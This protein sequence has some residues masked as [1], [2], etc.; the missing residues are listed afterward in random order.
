MTNLIVRMNS[1]MNSDVLPT[2]FNSKFGFVYAAVLAVLVTIIYYTTLVIYNVYFHPLSKF[3]GTRARAATEW[4]YFLSMINGTGP[5]DMLEM[6]EK[7]GPIVRVS[8]GELAFCS[9]AAFKDIYGRRKD[10]P[11]ELAK[12]KK[13]YSGMGEPTLLNSD[14][15]A[16]HSYLRK[17]LSPSFS[18]FSLRKQEAVIQDYLKILMRKLEK[19]SQDYDGGAD[20]LQWFNFFV[21]DV[22]GYLTY[23]ET[24]DCLNSN[25]L[26][27]W[28]KLIPPLGKFY[29]FYQAVARLPIWL[30]Y[31]TLLL[32]MPRGLLSDVKTLGQISETKVKQRLSIT[33]TIPDLMGK[34]IEEYN[35]GK[36]TMNQLKS[37]A[38]FLIGAGSETLVT[39]F[40]HCVYYLLMNPHT[41]SKLTSE[42]RG[43]FSTAD[44]ITMVN[45]NQCKY[46]QAVIDE[47]LRIVAPSPATH[48]RYTPPGGIDI[49]GVFVPG[50]MAV[51]VPILAACRSSLNFHNPTKFVPERWTGEDP[52]YVNDA[53]DAA[54]VFSYGPRDCLGR[55]LAYVEMR[56]VMAS[57]VWH[58]DLERR[59]PEDWVDQKVYMVW[60]KSP[61]MV[62]L[63]PVR[64]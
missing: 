12:D 40:T 22:I 56:L 39:M 15:M 24:F 36:M 33:A 54:Q 45:V 3:P 31:P 59:F 64:C 4:P 37:N 5:Q 6:H 27:T 62:K 53:R 28:I 46:L 43:S 25:E 20:L 17:L 60:V 58:F 63:K 42:I 48:P 49:D 50:G 9:P 44:E 30:K 41:L 51:G 21:F 55:N 7:Y 32:G 11:P 26:H 35:V 18:D 47:T 38:S 16:Y 29:A 57:L 34:L 1:F 10:G 14:D 19:H 2:G 23:G 8:P 13:Y 52:L 61:L